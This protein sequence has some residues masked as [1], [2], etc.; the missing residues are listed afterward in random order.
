MMN[1]RTPIRIQNSDDSFGIALYF[2]LIL[3]KV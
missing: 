1:I 2:T 3:S